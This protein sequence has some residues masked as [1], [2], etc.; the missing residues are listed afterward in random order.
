M[1]WTFEGIH[2]LVKLQDVDHAPSSCKQNVLFT[3]FRCMDRACAEVVLRAQ[4]ALKQG[5]PFT[6][7]EGQYIS[8]ALSLTLTFVFR[9]VAINVI[10]IAALGHSKTA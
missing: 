10:I 6:G 7:G 1:K 8:L 4:H 2:F 9:S 3:S 5:V